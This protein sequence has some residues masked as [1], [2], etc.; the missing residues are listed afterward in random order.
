MELSELT[1]VALSWAIG[2][3]M[4]VGTMA[5][6]TT[7]NPLR[8]LWNAGLAFV[9]GFFINQGYIYLFTPS[10]VGTFWGHGH[11]FFPLFISTALFCAVRGLQ[12]ARLNDS[13]SRRHDEQKGAIAA[14]HAIGLG[15]TLVLA[16]LVP[17]VTWISTDI[18]YGWGTANVHEY[19]KLAN[20][21][22]ASED[23]KLPEADPGRIQ[24]VTEGMAYYKCHTSIT[25]GGEAMS[26]FFRIHKADMVRQA[27][28]DR[29]Y[30]VAP[31]SHANGLY[32]FMGWVK[33]SPGFCMVDS[34]NPNAEAE[35]ILGHA[36]KVLPTGYWMENLKRHV[37]FNGFH[38]CNLDDPGI[39]IDDN[40]KPHATMTCTTPRFVTGGEVM[41]SVVVVDLNTGKI[42]EYAPDAVPAWIERVMSDEIVSS[43]QSYWGLYGNKDVTWLFNGGRNQKKKADMDMVYNSSSKAF[44]SMPMTSINSS[45]S[46]ATGLLMYETRANAGVYYPGVSGIPVGD[47]VTK[48]FD[49]AKGNVQKFKVKSVQLYPINGQITYV[50]IYVQDQGERGETFAGVGFAHARHISVNNVIF[51]S[52]MQ[53]AI[54]RYSIWLSNMGGADVDISKSGILT[55][56]V[57][58]VVFR[59]GKMV[60]SGVESYVFMLNGDKRFYTISQDG[61][62][63]LPLVQPGDRVE[64]SFIETDQPTVA[65]AGFRDLTIE[66]TTDAK[67]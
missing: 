63:K 62:A 56:P 21:R 19:G 15:F 40:K 16:F 31:L 11:M 9:L 54:A 26:S 2:L 35:M 59:I 67:K 28:G 46:A 17:V 4:M 43:Y 49:E 44:W 52:S 37:Y 41:K 57:T 25:K 5:A 38:R 45:D 53:E 1:I 8:G 30:F 10:F 13:Y 18:Y 27:V 32:Q 29:T 51:A 65:V 39:E 50:G 23:E 48:A 42:N 66:E 47:A 60:Q 22:I 34:E 61:Y 64:F 7:R 14:R 55:K 24:A 58:G 3:A 12:A 20:V 6:V 33:N 36:F